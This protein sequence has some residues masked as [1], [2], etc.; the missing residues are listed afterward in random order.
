MT[1]VTGWKPSKKLLAKNETAFTISSSSFA[2]AVES[3][4]IRQANTSGA[5]KR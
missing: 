2:S 3:D 4:N 5:L 1:A